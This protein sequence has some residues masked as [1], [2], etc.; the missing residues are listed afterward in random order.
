MLDEFEIDDLRAQVRHTKRKEPKYVEIPEDDPA[1]EV[2][3]DDRTTK[4]TAT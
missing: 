2:P 3:E 1:Y 4:P